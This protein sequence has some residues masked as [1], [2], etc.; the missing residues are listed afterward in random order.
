MQY[1]GGII[2]NIIQGNFKMRKRKS[3][4]KMSFDDIASTLAIA[5]ITIV[6][7]LAALG[8]MII[9]YIWGVL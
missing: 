9:P 4:Y 3:S 6:G 2:Q 5:T 1:N 8:V 7:F